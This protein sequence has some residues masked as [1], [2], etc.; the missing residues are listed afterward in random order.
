MSL[1]N[2]KCSPFNRT[3][4]VP[5]ILSLPAECGVNLLKR[6]GAS[7]FSVVS[8][9]SFFPRARL[10]HLPSCPPPAYSH[11]LPDAIVPTPT[12]LASPDMTPRL[13]DQ[14]PLARC[15]PMEA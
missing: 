8:S 11:A 15:T 6:F 2:C 9:Q 10:S 13:Q 5:D 12:P 7:C 4:M 14:P 3:V 1:N